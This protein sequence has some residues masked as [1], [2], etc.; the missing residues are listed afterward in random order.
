MKKVVFIFSLLVI[1]LFSSC[2]DENLDNLENGNNERIQLIDKDD[3]QEP[4]DRD[5]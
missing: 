3:I 1:V 4:D 5:E 2:T